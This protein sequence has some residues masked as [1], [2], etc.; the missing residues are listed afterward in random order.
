MKSYSVWIVSVGAILLS[1]VAIVRAEL[2]K[3]ETNCFVEHV[4]YFT[5]ESCKDT[6]QLLKMRDRLDI[7][8]DRLDK[9]QRT[10]DMPPRAR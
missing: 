10:G 7:V 9:I 6:E 5:K 2:N 1:I 4:L 8:E 3:Y